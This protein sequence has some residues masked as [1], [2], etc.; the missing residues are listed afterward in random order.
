MRLLTP[1]ISDD[2]VMQVTSSEL[3]Y[4]IS[5]NA[6]PDQL[7]FRDEYEA[8]LGRSENPK[9]QLPGAVYSKPSPNTVTGVPPKASPEVGINLLA[10]SAT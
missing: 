5:G 7:L 1:A 8:E 2:G 9:R 6:S 3:K 10:L 4:I